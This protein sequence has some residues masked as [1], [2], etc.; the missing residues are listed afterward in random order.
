MSAPALVGKTS[1]GE[2]F[3][4]RGAPSWVC[5]LVDELQCD[6]CLEFN[7][8]PGAAPVSLLEPPR[9]WQCLGIVPFE[10]VKGA[11]KQYLVICVDIAAR[12]CAVGKLGDAVPVK[13]VLVPATDQM[14]ENV[15]S[16]WIQ[17]KPKPQWFFTDPARCFTSNAFST[18]S[19]K[20]GY[21]HFVT[22]GE[23]HFML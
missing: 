19:S 7:E 21:G 13:S 14:I 4:R 2:F 22:A 16:T 20:Q 12:L 15:T 23:A 3:K 11:I 17:H 18:W 5:D 8:K 1:F 9:L 6:T 10:V